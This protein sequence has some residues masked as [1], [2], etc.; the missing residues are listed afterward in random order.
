MLVFFFFFRLA[1]A[2]P[3]PVG[4]QDMLLGFC[5]LVCGFLG[6]AL[7]AIV[8]SLFTLVLHLQY[9]I[10]YAHAFDRLREQGRFFW[11]KV[12]CLQ[13]VTENI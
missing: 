11:Y 3:I 4:A 5:A 13:P 6:F 12:E 2:I 8:V 1:G 10:P 9:C 7:F